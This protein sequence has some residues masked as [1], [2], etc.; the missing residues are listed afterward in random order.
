MVALAQERV[1]LEKEQA[2]VQRRTHALTVQAE[3]LLKQKV[4][5]RVYLP[6][7]CGGCQAAL[8][9]AMQQS[10]PAERSP[11][12]LPSPASPADEDAMI[13]ARRSPLRRALPTADTKSCQVSSHRTLYN[14]WHPA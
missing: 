2:K 12:Q 10:A 11:T 5:A 7:D 6:C 3:A 13:D 14:P 1:E 8:K 9:D 4:C